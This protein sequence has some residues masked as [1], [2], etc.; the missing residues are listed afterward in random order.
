MRSFPRVWSK[1]SALQD[2]GEKLTHD[3]AILGTPLYMAPEQIEAKGQ[4]MG[5]SVDQY[6]LGVMLYQLL[7]GETTETLRGQPPQ[8]VIHRPDS[9]AW[10]RLK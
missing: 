2:G 9:N 8:A 1:R 4:L 3:Q 6:S 10:S 7:A 5:P